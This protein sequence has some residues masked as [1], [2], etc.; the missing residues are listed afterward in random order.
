MQLP[1]IINQFTPDQIKVVAIVSVGLLGSAALY[2]V[3]KSLKFFTSMKQ[4]ITS[5]KENHLHTIQDNT[6][7]TVELLERMV[8]EQAEFNSYLRGKLERD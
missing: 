3:S 4:D 5:I 8:Y 6:G 1:D 7:R 2:F